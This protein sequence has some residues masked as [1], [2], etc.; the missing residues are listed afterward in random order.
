MA[1]NSK[2]TGNTNPNM[3]RLYDFIY[4]VKEDT[5]NKGSKYSRFTI[6]AERV[7]GM[8]AIPIGDDEFDDEKILVNS[9]ENGKNGKIV[10]ISGIIGERK[11]NDIMTSAEEALETCNRLNQKEVKRVDEDREEITKRL[12]IELKEAEDAYK[13]YKEMD[14]DELIKSFEK[15]GKFK[16]ITKEMVEREFAVEE[17][18]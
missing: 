10:R 15:P 13:F 5:L 12:N 1:R 3:P 16:K 17:I 6:D 2:L 4:T 7:M 9:D 11:V 8:R 18:R 14:V